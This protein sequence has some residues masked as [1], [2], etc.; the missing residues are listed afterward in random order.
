MNRQNNKYSYTNQSDEYFL[1][2]QEI[3]DKLVLRINSRVIFVKSAFSDK[4]F[5]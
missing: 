4:K 1:K 3:F 5:F 2:N